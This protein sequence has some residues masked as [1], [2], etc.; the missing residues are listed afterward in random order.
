V[1]T[2]LNLLFEQV[3]KQPNTVIEVHSRITD[4]PRFTP[5]FDNYISAIN[6]THI[7]AHPGIEA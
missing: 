7:Y 3:V 5:Y 1:L 6:S 2:A 4:N